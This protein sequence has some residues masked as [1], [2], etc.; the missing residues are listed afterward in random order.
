[1]ASDRVLEGGH[2]CTHGTRSPRRGGKGTASLYPNT[3]AHD[4][5]P[6]TLSH[7]ASLFFFLHCYATWL[8]RWF[9]VTLAANHAVEYAVCD[10]CARAVVSSFRAFP[11]F[12]SFLRR[13]ASRRLRPARQRLLSTAAACSPFLFI[14]RQHSPCLQLAFCC[15]GEEALTARPRMAPNA[16]QTPVCRRSSSSSP[17]I[18]SSSIREPQEAVMESRVSAGL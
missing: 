9:G 15:F 14:S 8:L 3:A 1:M 11:T 6:V 7:R 4:V 16:V 18:T 5:R 12:I 10:S 2:R 17:S 13:R